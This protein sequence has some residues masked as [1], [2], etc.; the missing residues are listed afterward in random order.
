[1]RTSNAHLAARAVD[2]LVVGRRR[3]DDDDTVHDGRWR[4]LLIVGRLERP[5]AQSDAQVDRARC[6]EVR[7][8]RARRGIDRQQTCIDRRGDDAP[9]ARLP[10]GPRRIEP[11]RHA[12][13]R[14]VAE[15]E[16]AIESRVV[17]PLLLAGL[18]IECDDAAEWRDEVHHAVHDDRRRLERAMARSLY[19]GRELTGVI[20]PRDGEPRDVA[21]VDLRQ[22][23]VAR[24][25]DV[26]AVRG[27]FTGRRRRRC[28]RR[29][30]RGTTEQQRDRHDGGEAH[31][32]RAREEQTKLAL[33]RRLATSSS[34]AGVDTEG[35]A[36]KR[37]N[38][39]GKLVRAG[40]SRGGRGGRGGV[41]EAPA[42]RTAECR[43]P[44]SCFW[45]CGWRGRCA[46]AISSI[47]ESRDS[48]TR[49][50]RSE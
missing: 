46:D 7:A 37:F 1:M 13:A 43:P 24:A 16:R 5:V 10:C 36:T 17:H 32:P 39:L 26:L 38:G 45:G 35:S 44:S 3:T 25:E 18:R 34:S 47:P 49:C 22:V 33:D 41:P 21:R 8:E 19:G 48:S 30:M 2:L 50:A 40:V 15:P 29:R 12:A 14:V 20:R 6:A 4:G 11:G 31:V 27:P 9:T 28:A 23:G 42:P